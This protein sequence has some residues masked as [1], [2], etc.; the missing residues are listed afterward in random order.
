MKPNENVPFAAAVNQ[1]QLSYAGPCLGRSLIHHVPVKS[2]DLENGS[3]VG[4][5]A[6]EFVP[7][8]HLRYGRVVRN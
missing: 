1:S 5:F 2:L 4:C 7:A 6:S 3:R 8:L